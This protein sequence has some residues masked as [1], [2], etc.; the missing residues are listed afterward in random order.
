[1]ESKSKLEAQA[2]SVLIAEA[3][4]IS[5]EHKPIAQAKSRIEEHSQ[6][7]LCY[8]LL[9]NNNRPSPPGFLVSVHSK[10]R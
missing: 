4:S 9:V 3:E 2:K 6:D 5:Q 1:M 7:W 10:E 8:L